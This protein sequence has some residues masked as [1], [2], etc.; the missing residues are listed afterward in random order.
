MTLTP[1]VTIDV[2]LTVIAALNS[3]KPAPV[4]GV[5]GFDVPRGCATMAVGCELPEH[6]PMGVVFYPCAASDAAAAAGGS[7]LLCGT[8]WDA[9]ACHDF[10]APRGT[11]A[12]SACVGAGAGVFSTFHASGRVDVLTTADT[13]AS[14]DGQHL[15]A[16]SRITCMPLYGWSNIN[17]GALG[18]QQ[19][20]RV[21]AGAASRGSG[22]DSWAVSLVTNATAHAPPPALFT[23]PARCAARAR[24]AVLSACTA[25]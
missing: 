9:E 24:A 3:A 22:E 11:A 16:V 18:M 7:G 4:P 17:Y 1:R 6:S 5:L 19:L 21:V 10:T 25:D 20:G 23:L 12:P 8:A 15:L 13:F 2:H 14:A